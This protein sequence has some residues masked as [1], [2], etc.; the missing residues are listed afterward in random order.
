MDS[1]HL[2]ASDSFDS[3]FSLRSF[4]TDS[5][6]AQQEKDMQRRKELASQRLVLIQN[7]KLAPGLVKILHEIF[8]RY[9]GSKEQNTQLKHV[10][11]VRLW[12]R[13]GLTLSN[14]DTLIQDK[15]K[16]QP[17]QICFDD[18]LEVLSSVIREEEHSMDGQ[19]H[20]ST[21][22]HDFQVC[23]VM[24]EFAGAFCF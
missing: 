9:S 22:S 6:Q 16:S 10:E 5:K 14:L 23:L 12:Y 24:S 17:I 4:S 11:A 13:C 20:H 21:E 19:L 2:V 7:K 3:S 18:F 8:V 15:K 1:I